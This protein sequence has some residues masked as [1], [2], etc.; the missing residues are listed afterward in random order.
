MP[1][2]HAADWAAW[3]VWALIVTVTTAGWTFII[4]AFAISWR[5]RA[6]P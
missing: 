5:D 6:Q 3:T 4:W 1:E 2:I